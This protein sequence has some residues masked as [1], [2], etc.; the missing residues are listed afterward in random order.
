MAGYD[1]LTAPDPAAWLALDEDERIDLVR[2]CHKRERVRLPNAYLHAVMHVIVENQIALG[3]QTPVCRT[4]QRLMTEGL[5]RHDA[6]H[7]IGSV[8]AGHV[9]D[10]AKGALDQAA[11][12]NQAYFDQLEQLAAESWLSSA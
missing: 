5:D 12:P 7:A 10:I 11:D 8:L 1:P 9:Y 4:L 3:D 6:V 2:A